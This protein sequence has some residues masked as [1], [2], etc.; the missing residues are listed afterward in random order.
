MTTL[1]TTYGWLAGAEAFDITF[2]NFLTKLES[3]VATAY[4]DNTLTYGAS[5]EWPGLLLV[6]PVNDDHR[7]RP[8]VFPI[9][10]CPSVASVRWMVR[11]ALNDVDSEDNVDVQYPQEPKWPDSELNS[12]IRE[13]IGYYNTFDSQEYIIETD[14]QLIRSDMFRHVTDVL[15]V[16][17]YDTRTQQ[18][19]QITQAGR[20]GHRGRDKQWDMVSGMLR[21]YGAFEDPTR[22]EISVVA[23]YRV[24]VND[25]QELTV[26]DQDWDIL[27]LYAQAR[28]Y[29]RL[30]G[31][32][33]QLDR[34]KEEGRRNDN[35]ITPV[36]KI[37][38]TTLDERVRTRRGPRVI[39]R[40]RG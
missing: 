17:Y 12:Y 16:S 33:A 3:I 6:Y 14:T 2:L 10:T 39:K 1:Y 37:I 40:Y 24:P 15:G 20:R 19:L 18:W 30:A 29:L 38:M 13:A 22:L 28:A 26:P 7:S 31:Q 35:P 8:F 21:L 9:N 36:V 34:W 11:D 25:F 27:S 5:D 4:T 32:S 23:P